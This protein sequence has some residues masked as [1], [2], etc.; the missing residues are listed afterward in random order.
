MFHHL[1]PYLKAEGL[2]WVLS[3]REMHRPAGRVLTDIERR[4][5]LAFFTPATL[6]TVR[7]C[8]VEEIK[9]PPFYKE[10]DA[11]GIPPPFDFRLAAGI[12]FVD[13][14][15][16]APTAIV[17]D[18]EIS[19]VF[20]ECVHVVQYL[21]LGVDTFIDRYIAGWAAN[22]FDYFKIPLEEEASKLQFRFDRHR[23]IPFS[24]EDVVAEYLR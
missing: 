6:N 2:R 22:G 3:Q 5:L 21:T 20:H 4:I 23:H 1:I 18:D 13:T 7:L 16:I 24:V 8:E 15:L 11:R 17:F 14:V 9:N 12:T 10:L 19:V